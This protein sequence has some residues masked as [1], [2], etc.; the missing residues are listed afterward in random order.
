MTD[1]HGRVDILILRLAEEL[2]RRMSVQTGLDFWNGNPALGQSGLKQ[3]A[4]Q[5][6]RDANIPSEPIDV[7]MT[8]ARNVLHLVPEAPRRKLRRAG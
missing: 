3:I 2:A 1:A 8:I 7:P 5:I 4:E 6:I